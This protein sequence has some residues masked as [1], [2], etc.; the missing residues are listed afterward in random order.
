M[1]DPQRGCIRTGREKTKKVSPAQISSEP[2]SLV[3]A[4]GRVHPV[5]CAGTAGLLSE[6]KSGPG[7]LTGP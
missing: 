4:S 3:D 1:C 7:R 2:T 6:S 5:K